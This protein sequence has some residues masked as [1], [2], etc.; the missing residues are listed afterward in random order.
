[1]HW[2]KRK[3]VGIKGFRL[4]GDRSLRYS[5]AFLLLFL[6][7]LLSGCVAMNDPETSQEYREDVVGVVSPQE[8]IGQ[9]IV[10]RR[11]GLNSLTLWLT[12]TEPD[13]LVTL[14]LYYSPEDENPIF[15]TQF[16]LQDGKN[17]IDMPTQPDPPGQGYYFELSTTQGN[18]K[19]PRSG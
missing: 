11:A 3:S 7:V 16:P 8:P 6:G 10:S 1:M 19:C 15:G 2:E 4:G 13:I 12:S 17:R 18:R 5:P 9:T 14:K